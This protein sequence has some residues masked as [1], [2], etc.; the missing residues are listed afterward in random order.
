MKNESGCTPEVLQD[1]NKM[2]HNT[3]IKSISHGDST[4]CGRSD[5]EIFFLEAWIL[6]KDSLHVDVLFAL[7]N[8]IQGE[9]KDCWLMAGNYCDVSGKVG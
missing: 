1:T 3:Q 4:Y 6:M 2:A 5:I 9:K 8:N 7:M